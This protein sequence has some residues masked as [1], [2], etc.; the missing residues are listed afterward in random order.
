MNFNLVDQWIRDFASLIWGYP[1][2]IFLI[3]IGLYFS[4]RLKGI[5]FSHFL[6]AGQLT[7][8]YREGKGEGNLTPLQ[9]LYGALGGM[10]GN[11]NLGGVAAAVAVGGPGAIFWLWVSS[12]IAMIIVYAE[13]L[14]AMSHRKK[15]S[16]GT[17]SGGPMY[18]IAHLLKLRWLA[19]LFAMA[20][21]FKALLATT[22]VQSNSI[23]L[24]ASKAFDLQWLPQKIPVLLPVSITIA[25]LTWLV[26][27]G[28][29]RSIASVLKM[30]TPLMVIIYLVLGIF[31]L[32]KYG[33]AFGETI[34][35]IISKAF[36]PTGVSGGFAGASVIMTIRFGVARG[37]YSNEA[38]TGSSAIMFSTAKC[39]DP[40]KQSLISMFGVFIDTIIGTLTVV[41][42]VICGVWDSGETST[43]LTTAAFR[44]PFGVYGSYIV[45]FTSF[46][47][48]YSTLIAWCFYGEQCFVYV[49]GPKIRKIFRWAFCTFIIFGFMEAELVWSI[50]D[51]LNASIVIINVIALFLL[52]KHVVSYT[53]QGKIEKK[54]IF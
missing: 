36:T 19:T 8:Q 53:R 37:F 2:L 13:T 49:W 15:S 23:S 9:S 48:G 31:I 54:G 46:L 42:V 47:F 29:L 41:I 14:L 17:F 18:Y 33:D 22:T 35:L 10:I 28:G 6:K 11:G 43:A 7:Y 45:F 50:A 30:L 4:F 40:V 25:I 27:I 51:L 44:V 26:V 5:Q 32:I 21:G 24:A 3:L 39:D 38:G 12:F 20:M 1:M 34:R 52:I 16:D